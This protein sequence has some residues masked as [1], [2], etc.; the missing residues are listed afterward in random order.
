VNYKCALTLGSV[1]TAA[2]S[3]FFK[4]DI[5][6]QVEDADFFNVLF[7]KKTTR[8]RSTYEPEEKKE[9]NP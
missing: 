6:Q 2:N 5:Q 9:S 8:N 3:L 4:L 7:N 1:S